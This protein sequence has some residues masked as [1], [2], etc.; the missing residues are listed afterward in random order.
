[1]IEYIFLVIYII[2]AVVDLFAVSKDSKKLEYIAKP[3]LMPILALYFIFGTFKSGID[4][5][6]VLAILSGCSGDIFLML[7]NEEK[8]FMYGMVGFLI[9]HIFYIIAFLLSVGENIIYFPLW[10]LILILPVIL[11]LFLTFPKY[12]NYMGDLRIP[13]YVYIIAILFMHFSSILRLGAFDIFCPCFFLVYIGSLLFITSDSMIAIDTFKEDM[14]IPHFYMM[15]T[16][17]LGQF[18]IVQGIL[19]SILL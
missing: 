18:L 7:E 17:I 9:G 19:M 8:W 1:M 11:I 10:G 6:I 12:K 13:V 4:W 2:V 14:E 5:L 16:Y 15:L 3:L